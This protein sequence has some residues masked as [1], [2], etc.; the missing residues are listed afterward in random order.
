[1]LYEVTLSQTDLD[2]HDRI[3]MTSRVDRFYV[4]VLKNIQEDR[5]F[6][7]HKEYKVDEIGLLWFKEIQYVQEEGDIR[8]SILTEFH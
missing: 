2:L 3:R 8:T 1:M 6:E 5:L 7:Q 4:E